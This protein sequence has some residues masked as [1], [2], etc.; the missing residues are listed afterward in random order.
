MKLEGW[1]KGNYAVY[2][3]EKM[4]IGSLGLWIDTIY[5]LIIPW[6]I[7]AIGIKGA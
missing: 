1:C 2:V 5:M 4:S 7:R 3:K 6:K